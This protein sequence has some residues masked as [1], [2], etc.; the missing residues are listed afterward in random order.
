M[1]EYSPEKVE[2]QVSE[3][4]EKNNVKQKVR[5]STEGNEPFFL[6]DGP[7][8]LNGSPHVGH[9]QGKVIKDV[10]LRFKQMQ[11]HEV[12]DQ[13]GFDTHGLPNELATE[14]E[15]GIEDKNEIGDSIS[16]KKFIEECRNRATSAKD[17][18][19]TVMEDL[20][21]WQD[22]EDPYMTYDSDYI[23]TAWWL[24]SKTDDQDLVYQ[25]YKPIH[26]CP[27]CQTSLSGYEVTDEYQEIE[28]IA[29]F[30]KFPLENREEKLV[31]WTTT[32]WTI[33]S[34][35]AV[36]THPDYQYAVV[37]AEGE[38]LIIAE[39]LVERVMEK[40]GLEE[41]EYEIERTLIGSDLKGLKYRTPFLDDIPKQQELDEENGVHRVHNSTDLVTLEEGTGL[42]HAATGHGPEDYEKTRSLGL[43]V[44]SPLDE[45]GNYTE[46]AGD[47]EGENVLDVDPEI[48]ERL[49]EKDLLFY[50]EEFRHEYP[51]C[52]RC[53]TELIYRAAEQWFIE[54]EEVKQRMLE[55]NE[56]VDWIP[57]SA[58]KRFHNFVEESPDW[59]IS[60][61][62]YWGI[63]IPIWVN[64]ETGEYQVIGSFEEL[65]EKAGG[66]PENFD[67]HKH[68]VDDITWEGE[69][70][71]TFRRIPDIFDVW[72]DSGIAPFASL[73]YPFE[74][75]PFESMWP[76]DFITEASDQIRGWFY[77]LMF[78]GILGFDE[79]PYEKI[80][81]QGYVLDAEGE[82]MSKSLGN[83]V[84]PAEQLEKFGAD[85]PRF[86]QLRLAPSWEQ[87][88][89]DEEEIRNEIYRLFSVYWNTKEFL[90]THG[91][92]VE[93]PE[94]LELEDKWILSRINS[95]ADGA[96]QKMD[97]CLFHEL[98]RDIE[99]FIVKD[100]S[101]WYVKKVRD[102]IKDGDKAAN[103]TLQNVLN[104]VNLLMAPFA[105]YI[106]EKIYQELD[107]EELSVHMESYPEAD[108][109][110]I[111]KEI[112]ERMEHAREIVE[113]ST[114]IRDEN[115]YNLRWPAKRLVISTSNKEEE[116]I[117]EFKP[118]IKDMANVKKIE[119]GEVASQLTAEPD[120]SKLGPKFGENAEE[121]AQKIE[122]LDHDQIEQLRDLG[123]LEL[124]KYQIEE[125][126]VEITSETSE[127][128]GSK[129]VEIGEI[130]LDLHMTD[131]IEDE[132][133]VAEVVRAIQQGRKE[134][135]LKV[136]DTVN[137]SFS[138]DTKPIE[139]HESEI[140]DRMNVD[141]ISY[142]GEEYTHSEEVDFQGR[143]ARFRFSDPVA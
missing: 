39:Q 45:E 135:E 75:E 54:N 24:L 87:K 6:I 69:N 92:E 117:K 53:K 100:L 32:P 120:Y 84:D 30:A 2:K 13:A 143:K 47:L 140:R 72:F 11:G 23:E 86:Y 62:N 131:E 36:F 80:L 122:E 123:E 35:M 78:T 17:D 46:E 26:W 103:W 115:Q 142:N 125:E 98:T 68:V 94:D 52:W 3:H 128:V 25:G 104:K 83:V 9:M 133:F 38:K 90:K 50:S 58:Q 60:R 106:T 99:D 14:E 18:W 141:E 105:P 15:L 66:L 1:T 91:E 136:E 43:P 129:S 127:D 85:L 113:K 108:E 138:G 73:H 137:L 79:A 20:A 19:Q 132:A 67:P 112:E 71:G 65:E 109:E 56:D 64:D 61:Q 10:M 126:D 111:D 139:E 121:V 21:I 59:C 49:D 118:L 7:P 97:D 116:A 102:R 55:E 5:E 114:K 27:R 31:I 8:Y 77:S 81:F 33:P 76:M 74:E 57:D 42:V 51:H 82:K 134:A 119:F 48:I 89:Y 28:D 16:A 12:W 40:K 41:E 130:Y 44:Y 95:I 96:D 63:P 124:K 34:N 29:V 88:N 101:R 37:E 22:F 107:G 70:G 110:R 93:R 4:W